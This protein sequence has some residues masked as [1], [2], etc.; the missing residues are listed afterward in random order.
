MRAILGKEFASV[1]TTSD[2][3]TN[4]L[5]VQG[6]AA[7]IEQVEQRV[8]REIEQVTTSQPAPR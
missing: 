8:I 7:E 1:E 3:A 4:T 2:T 5:V 6:A